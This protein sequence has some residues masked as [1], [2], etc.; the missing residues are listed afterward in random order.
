MCTSQCEGA[1]LQYSSK[2]L[3]PFQITRLFTL[4]VTQIECQ[5]TLLEMIKRHLTTGQMYLQLLLV[6]AQAHDQRKMRSGMK[7]FGFV[8][9]PCFVQVA[10]S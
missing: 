1:M 7:I 9:H 6:T 4:S 2:I 10:S 3:K 5:P 8:A